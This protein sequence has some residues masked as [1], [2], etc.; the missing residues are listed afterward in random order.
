M[1]DVSRKEAIPS[2]EEQGPSIFELLALLFRHR[3]TLVLGS[4]GAGVLAA[5]A[6]YLMAPVFTA[7][8]VFLPPQQQQSIAA[9]A[10]ASLGSLSG[11]VGTVGNFKNPADQYVS[12]L[13]SA[14]VGDA[15]IDRFGLM[16][17]YHSKFRS[18]AR[19]L[20]SQR[21]QISLGVRDGLITVEMDDTDPKRAADIANG[22]VEELRRITNSLALTDAQQRRVFFQ[23]QLDQTSK[24]LGSAQAALQASGFDAG[25]IKAE[26][27]ATADS[28]ARIQAEVTAAEVRLQTMRRSLADNAPEVQQ[29]LAQLGALRAQV[30][31]LA[32]T[33]PSSGGPD[34][35]SKYRR[36]KYEEALFE[37]FSR[38]YELAKLDESRDGTLIQVVD[39]AAI[40]EHKSKPRR[41]Q[42]AVG[43]TLASLLAIAMAII[44]RSRWPQVRRDPTA[45]NA[46]IGDH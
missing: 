6:T 11:L 44:V 40:P 2:S 9:S 45:R 31:R 14:N 27:K 29:Q 42:I 3:W 4:L 19:D 1:A 17:V 10:L 16:N 22:Y 38:Q 24:R 37:I 30:D 18:E 8:T 25:A 39:V 5:G 28:Y 26:P 34:Y 23:G 15:L 7:R 33:T 43:T 12:L 21:A 35:I 32:T 46:D 41:A 13:K 20:L 36:Y